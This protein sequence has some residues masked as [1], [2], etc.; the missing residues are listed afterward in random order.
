M[1]ISI[2]FRHMATSEAIKTYAND[3]VAKLQKFLR[4]PMTAKVT[5]SIDRLKHI[6]ETRISSGGAHLEAKEA[7]ED[8]YGS[9][10]K[11][12]DKLER[13]I[14]GQKGAAEA[15]KKRGRESIKSSTVASAA[16][17]A[18]PVAKRVAKKVTRTTKKTGG[19]KAKKTRS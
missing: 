17:L 14:R 18:E 11:V 12:I 19:T 13:Q 5:L 3:K 15:K 1:N 16:P 2:T 8:M 7:S 9:I 10:D 6:A 4:Q